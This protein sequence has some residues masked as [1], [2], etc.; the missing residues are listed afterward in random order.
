MCAGFCFL[1]ADFSRP[2]S[3]L[4]LD[5]TSVLL[6]G[7][8]DRPLVVQACPYPAAAEAC[9]CCFQVSAQILFH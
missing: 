2:V 1:G 5:V 8:G 6:T 7:P 3:G 4:W 9:L